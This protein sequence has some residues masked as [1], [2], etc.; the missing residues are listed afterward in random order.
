MSDQ[1]K[2]ANRGKRIPKKR[3]W[4]LSSA[5][6]LGLLVIS[7]PTIIARTGI[8]DQLINAIIAASHLS[9]STEGASVGWLSPLSVDGLRINGMQNRFQV[10]VDRV[11]ADR[12][13]PRLLTSSPNLGKITVEKPHVKLMLPLTNEAALTTTLATNFTAA[14]HNAALSVE[15]DRLDEPLIDVNGIDLT[16]HLQ[17][18]DQ[19]MLLSVDSLDIYQ[20][21]E[22]TP[23]YCSQLLGMINPSLQDAAN[24][25]GEFSLSLAKFD[26][27]IGV[28][29]EQFLQHLQLQ[30]E[31]ALHQVAIETESELLQALSK[32]VADA[33][34]KPVPAQTRVV[35]DALIQFE[36]REGR[37]HHEGLRFG[38]PDIDP[39]LEIQ[40][41]GSVGLDQTLDAYIEIP[42][43]DQQKHDELGPIVCHV[44]GSV[45]NPRL[46]AKNATLVVHSPNR[47]APLIDVEGIDF[48]A[49]IENSENGR[50]ISF[51]PMSVLD[52][53][54]LD[55]Q[56]ASS[57]LQWLEPGMQYSPRMEGEVTLWVEHLRIPIEAAEEDL[58]DLL[59]MNGK[60]VIHEAT[61]F[62]ETPIRQAILQLVSDLYDKQPSDSVRIA[63]DDEVEFQLK[64]G[65]FHFDGLRVGLPDISPQLEITSHGSIGF[66]ETL[67]IFVS[68]PRLDDDKQKQHGPVQCHLT[69]TV[70]APEL[71]AKNASLVIHLPNRAEPLV[72]IDGIDLTMHVEEWKGNRVISVNPT[73]LMRRQKIDRQ[74]ATGLLQLVDPELQYFPE[75]VGEVSLSVDSLRIPVGA[76]DK[77]WVNAL[78]AHGKLEIHQATSL[79]KSPLRMAITKLLADLYSIHPGE[80][81]RMI[82]DA[83]IEFGLQESRF[84]F[85]GLRF[86]F[87][88]IDEALQIQVEGSIGLDQTLDLQLQLPRLDGAKR[89]G[90][91]VVHCRIT[92]TV[93]HP[94]F[95]VTDA[96]LIVRLPEHQQPLLDIDTLDFD[97][98]IQFEGDTPVLQ[99]APT[100]IFDHQ[101]LTTQ[102]SE[103][104]LRLIAPA[105]ADVTAMEGDL[106]LTINS[107]RIPL[108]GSQQQLLRSTEL[109]GDLQL[110]EVTT[111]VETPLLSA[112]VKVLADQ[113][114]KEASETIRIAKDAK[115]SFE[116]R[117]GRLFQKGLRFGFPD[118]SPDLV[119]Q[120][121]GSVGLDRTLDL[122]LQVPAALAA[123][124]GGEQGTVRFQV[125]GTID[126]P[127]V[128]ELED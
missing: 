47:D 8:R 59:E 34:D 14:I 48:T 81:I 38:F 70:S 114:G 97:M 63:L 20:H 18:S 53:A 71:A 72:D 76:Q 42:R 11:T 9:A 90:K 22:L 49:Q 50:M 58:P 75:I 13:W 17:E 126:D 66:D 6:L 25:D 121:N 108:S 7:T 60:L 122:T 27:P 1:K 109:S 85:S 107:L 91:G 44:T 67:D 110:H 4:L 39:E 106:S 12:S 19:G 120:T 62:A 54:K 57:L 30:G 74:L 40:T 15:H 125:T 31:L 56:L 29:E 55:R 36:V 26:V 93:S 123:E 99:L 73:Q 83:E 61:S 51:E 95:A 24:I 98:E 105:I 43:F 102:R 101:R 16:V 23:K 89:A 92:G 35:K 88:D 79:V 80:S 117:D 115:I 112:M 45:S 41:Y 104:W 100:R 116:L 32:L 119:L 68:V 28:T 96:S 84:Q 113:Y 33:H 21:E 52:H 124:L 127:Q 2:I 65:R 3:V 78:E 111:K 46:S 94:Q 5:S 103:E 77:Q 69:G 64:E 10:E 82:H 87:P 86:G 118:L 37:L 128:V